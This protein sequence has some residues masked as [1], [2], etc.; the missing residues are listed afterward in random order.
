MINVLTH[1]DTSWHI[2]KGELLGK[3]PH[4]LE[5]LVKC[6]LKAP[7]PWE[8]SPALRVHPFRAVKLGGA[9][10]KP[11][12]EL[13][14]D[15][16]LEWELSSEPGPGAH[17]PNTPAPWQFQVCRWRNSTGSV[18]FWFKIR[19]LGFQRPDKAGGG[20]GKEAVSTLLLELLC[21]GT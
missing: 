3:H 8:G 20:E 9:S 7:V 12:Q 10:A 21:V 1:I 19:M 18:F 2:P 13:C 6:L 11:H 14:G 17:T 4:V 15:T 5:T 16:E